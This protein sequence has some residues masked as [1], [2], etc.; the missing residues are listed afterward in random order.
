MWAKYAI[1]EGYWQIPENMPCVYIPEWTNLTLRA[2][3]ESAQLHTYIYLY[4]TIV[5]VDL[6][7][8]ILLHIAPLYSI[9]K[10][11]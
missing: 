10:A 4:I 6:S 9:E 1:Y 2:S 11:F 8:T 7:I 5:I 3:Y